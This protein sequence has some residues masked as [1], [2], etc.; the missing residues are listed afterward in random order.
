MIANHKGE[1][2]FLIL[3]M[4]FILGI[5]A[6]VCIP[7]GNLVP[8]LIAAGLL[9]AIFLALAFGYQRF[10]LYKLKW[11]GGLTLHCILAIAGFISVSL[12][13]EL[14]QPD[15]FSKLKSDCLLVTINNEPKATGDLVRFTAITN[16]SILKGGQQTASGNLIISVKDSLAQKLAYGDMLLIPANYKPVEG[17]ANPAEFNYRDY[18]AYQN[19]HYQSFL[20]RGQYRIIGHSGGNALI[21]FSLRLR[22]QLVERFKQHMHHPE[23][24]AVASTLILGYKA[25]LNEDV[26]QA[27]AKTGTIHVLSVSGA[28]VAIVFLLL[29]FM[30]GFMNRFP[31]GR[32]IKA[33][34]II[35]FIWYYSLLTGF[36]PAVCRAAVMISMVIIGKTF[37]RH[38]NT[39]NILAVSAF[40]L[41]LY[42]PYFIADV[43]FQ[44]SYLAVFGLIAFQPVVYKWFA[45]D[46]KWLDKLWQLCSVSI[47]AQVITFPLSIF[48]FHQFPVY[49]LL[50]NLLIILPTTIIM[51]AGIGC[52]LFGFVP[53]ISAVFAFVLEWSIIFMNRMLGLIEHAPYSGVSRIWISNL[54]YLLLF[55]LIGCFFAFLHYKRPRLLMMGLAS[56]LLFCAINS[57]G[58]IRRMQ[59][60]EMIVL[61]LRK[62]TGIIFRHGDQAVVLTDLADTSRT[63]KYS[64]Q[65]Y[66]DSCCVD[67]ISIIAKDQDVTNS[68]LVKKGTLVGFMNKTIF[69][70]GKTNSP[71][72]LKADY[73]LIT[74]NP[75]I[76]PDILAK[77]PD[78]GKIIID[79]NN[80]LRLSKL[81]VD[82]CRA[83]HLNYVNCGNKC[84]RIEFSN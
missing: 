8:M 26:L 14:S 19:I 62:H 21:A 54:Q 67:K 84:V 33:T 59:T 37:S 4:P 23:S 53:V 52:L 76:T 63:F 81:L 66:L 41:L 31:H 82:A 12:Y 75:S 18:L 35:T 32:I 61:T 43:G 17:P 27:Y 65:P 25:D 5:G 68:W 13:N 55:I 83:H 45:I 15:H 40:G 60:D 1:I 73:L 57:F 7:I 74:G 42:D 47:A 10:N 79:D 51:Y 70:P 6:G 69:I 20:R 16:K 29:E 56:L 48:Y 72:S 49:F 28:H 64:V 11:I 77:S 78:M 39:L 80:T 2:P 36:S 71:L 22:Q 34:I 30:L 38:I 3:L 24:V 9:L 44:L 46:N 50:S 58:A